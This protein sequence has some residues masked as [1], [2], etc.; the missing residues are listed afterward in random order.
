MTTLQVLQA[1]A[2]IDRIVNDIFT[3]IDLFS[4]VALGDPLFL[5]LAL[6]ALGGLVITVAVVVFGGLSVAGLFSGFFRMAE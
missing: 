6:V 2:I 5:S 3:A 4:D 1:G